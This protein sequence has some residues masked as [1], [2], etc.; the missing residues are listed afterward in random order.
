MISSRSILAKKA[1]DQR[2]VHR[3]MHEMDVE[4]ARRIG[5]C[6]VAAIEDADL[7]ELEG[8][9][10]RHELHA[11]LLQRRAAIAE[12]I[13]ENPLDEFLAVNRPIVL[14]AEIL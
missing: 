11:R 4:E 1:L 14:D 10:V 5:D 12:I 3:V 8:R 6:G 2:M 7:H 13:L 9:H